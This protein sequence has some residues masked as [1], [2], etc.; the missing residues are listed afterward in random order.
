MSK[1]EFCHL[2]SFEAFDGMDVINAQFVDTTFGKHAHG[3]FVITLVDAG[4]QQFFHKGATHNAIS[5]DICVISQT[6]FI[7]AAK[8]VNKD[9]VIAVSILVNSKS[10]TSTKRCTQRMDCQPFV[11]APSLMSG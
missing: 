7:L 11:I 3:E 5:G 10:A 8:G 9:G 2:A 6:K 4:V 1:E